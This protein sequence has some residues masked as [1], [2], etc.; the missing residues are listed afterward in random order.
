[1]ARGGLLMVNVTGLDMP[2]S[3]AE[4]AVTAVVAAIARAEVVMAR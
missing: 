1:M 2:L 3:V 4:E